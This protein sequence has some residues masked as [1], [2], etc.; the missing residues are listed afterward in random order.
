MNLPKIIDRV[1][2]FVFGNRK[3]LLIVFTAATVLFTISASQLRVDA[4]FNKMVPLTHPYMK[5]YTEYAGVFGGA[6]RIAIALVQKQGGDIYNKEFMEKLKSL[7][8]DVSSCR[9][10]RRS[11]PIPVRRRR[12]RRS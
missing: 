8:K 9:W 11:G 12:A 6:N 3:V 5:V 2:A 7:T 10:R 1:S 4:G